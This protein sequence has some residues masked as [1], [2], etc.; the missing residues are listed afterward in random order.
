MAE[1]GHVFSL[2]SDIPPVFYRIEE[3]GGRISSLP[4]GIAA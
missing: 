3:E 4:F 2:Q 1:A